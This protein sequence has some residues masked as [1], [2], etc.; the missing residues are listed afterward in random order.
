MYHFSSRFSPYLTS[1]DFLKF[2]A[3]VTMLIDHVGFFF[4]P[5]QPWLRAIGRLSFPC[6]MF[7][8]GFANTRAVPKMLVGGCLA[9]VGVNFVLG[10]YILPLNILAL[11]ILM[12]LVLTPLAQVVFKSKEGL[13]YAFLLILI[14]GFLWFLMSS[15]RHLVS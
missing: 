8:V 4:F 10:Q 7:L 9:L 11:I 14:W 1:Y 12:R 13:F 5:D 6:W 15:I 3:V 2:F